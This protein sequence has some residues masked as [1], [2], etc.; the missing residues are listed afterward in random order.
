MTNV[1]PKRVVSLIA[2]AT[3]IVCALGAR[4]LLVGRSHECDFPP[5]VTCLP[6]L[7]E[8]KFPVTGT[9]YDIDARVKAI[10][11]EG[12]S[13]YR[14]DA[15]K[16]EV[17]RPDIII[18]QDHCEV[19]AVS[20]KDVEAALCA[21]GGRKVEIVSLKPDALGDIW[22]DIAKVARA[23]GRERQG[24]RLVEQLKARMASIAEQSDAARTRPRAA[25]IEWIDPLMAGGNWMPELVQMAGAENLFGVAG[26]PSPWLDWNEVVAADPDVILVHPCGIDMARTL[27]EMPLLER[28]PGWRELKAVHR[29]RIFVAD[30]NQYFNRPG[31]RIVESLEIMAEIFHPELFPS[32]YEGKGWMHYPAEPRVNKQSR[33]SGSTRG[34]N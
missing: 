6:A 23:L 7:T 22:E 16:L 1:Q 15:E 34:V 14:V 33:C 18:T 5:D 19:C 30:G 10:L 8:P 13:V 29:D 26:L 25:M 32:R 17:L 4:D 20:L 2:S 3:E 9:S 12:L 31:P 11:Q 27:Q 24:E 28:G 21:W